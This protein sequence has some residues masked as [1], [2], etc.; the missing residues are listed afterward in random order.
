[1][2]KNMNIKRIIKIMS[3]IR[4]YSMMALSEKMGRAKSYLGTLFNVRKSMGV[5]VALEI[6]DNLDCDVIVR[7]RETGMEMKVSRMD[8]EEE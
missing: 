7:D 3:A 5:E 2:N 1:M 8:S 4:G 6:L